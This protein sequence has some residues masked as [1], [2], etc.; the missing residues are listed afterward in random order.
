MKKFLNYFP[1]VFIVFAFFKLLMGKIFHGTEPASIDWLVFIAEVGASSFVVTL[2]GICLMIPNG[3]QLREKLKAGEFSLRDKQ[4]FCF[5]EILTTTIY[6]GAAANIFALVK[7][8]LREN[9]FY[10]LFMGVVCGTTNFFIRISEIRK[11][12]KKQTVKKQV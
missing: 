5:I 7:P 11:Y 12:L 10:V 2:T 4:K 3:K 6:W 9:V 1:V 8:T